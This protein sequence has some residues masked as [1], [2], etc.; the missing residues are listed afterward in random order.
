MKLFFMQLITLKFTY[1]FA[2]FCTLFLSCLV[3]VAQEK[4]TTFGIQLK[5][6]IPLGFIDG[7][8]QEKKVANINFEL[9]P[10]FGL[11]FGMVIRKGLTKNL[12][13]ESGI[14]LVR[15][16]YDLSIK[17]LDSSFT[18]QSSFRVVNYEIP[19]SGLVYVQL[20]R[21]TFM[22]VSG[23]FSFDMY[24]TPLFVGIDKEFSNAINRK[25]WIQ[26]SLIANVGWEYRTQKSGYLY[27]GASFHRPFSALLNSY[28]TYQAFDR[29]DQTVFSLSGNYLTLD[30]RY[31]FHEDKEKKKGPSE[32]DIKKKQESVRIKKKPEH[33]K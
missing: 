7:G 6:I 20:G 4:V 27:F 8:V 26:L 10:K 5:P 12:S 13:L 9:E 29:S 25:S 19:V 16:N 21:N 17:D 30:F 23:G 3:G 33:L 24:P 22:N 31:F 18:S 2:F 32:R 15:R 14:N 1:R 11:A 28:V